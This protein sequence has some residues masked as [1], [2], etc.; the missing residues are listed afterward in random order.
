MDKDKLKRIWDLCGAYL[1]M[2]LCGAILLLFPNSAVALVT[3]VLGWILVASGIYNVI[4]N[5]SIH[6][7]DVSHWLWP[8][9][10]LAMGIF[11]LSNPLSIG[12]GIGRCL[13]LILTVRAVQELRGGRSLSSML[14]LAAGVVLILVPQALFNTL[15]GFAGIL[16]IAIGVINVWGRL[17]SRHLEE[18]SDPNIIDADE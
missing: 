2:I 16:L 7:R 5:L 6:N 17:S 15:L 3:K 8:A 12:N 13:G 4:K 14:T 11:L 9:L 1:V 10:Y 18:G